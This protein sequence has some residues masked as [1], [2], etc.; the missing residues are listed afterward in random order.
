NRYFLR[1]RQPLFQPNELKNNLEQA[2]LNLQDAE[3]D[4]QN[5]AIQIIQNIADDY[6]EL[7]ENA[8]EGQLYQTTVENLQAALDVALEQA[9]AQPE[10]EI[11]ASRVRVALSNA[12]ATH[13]QSHSDVRLAASQ[14]KP[15]LG[16]SP[17]DS[18]FHS[19]VIDMVPVQ[20]AEALATQLG[21]TLRPQLRLLE[22]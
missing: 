4:F 21:L 19:P 5:D 10:R 14:I 13:Q 20:V 3:L 6:Y 12:E 7:F 18:I 1:Y 16:L 17:E 22:I 15:R 9:A 8:Y 2:E 11:D